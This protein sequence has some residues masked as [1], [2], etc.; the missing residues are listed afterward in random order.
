MSTS[1]PPDPNENNQRDEY[2]NKE[3]DINENENENENQID[4]PEED[5]EASRGRRPLTDKEQLRESITILLLIYH[6][7]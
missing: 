6:T 2:E 3:E 7:D 5:D 4:A 1:E